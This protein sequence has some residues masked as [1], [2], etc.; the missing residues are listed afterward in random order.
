MGLLRTGPQGSLVHLHSRPY[1]HRPTLKFGSAPHPGC[2]GYRLPGQ[3][4]YRG[5]R[6]RRESLGFL[7]CC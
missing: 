6:T 3:R 5:H 4:P 2:C 1:G 7:L